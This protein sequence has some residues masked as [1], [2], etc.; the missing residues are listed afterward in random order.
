MEAKSEPEKQSGIH[1]EPLL[2][3]IK[4][5]LKSGQFQIPTKYQ[6]IE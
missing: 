6:A 2:T 1:S 4:Q 3:N 5:S